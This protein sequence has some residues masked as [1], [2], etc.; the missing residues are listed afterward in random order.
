MNVTKLNKIFSLTAMVLACIGSQTVSAQVNSDLNSW[1]CV[2][3]CGT[4]AADGDITLSP[5]GNAKY[6]YVSTFN[7]TATNVSPLSI[8][9]SGGGGAKFLQTNGSAYTSDAFTLS[10]GQQVEAYFNYVSTDGK[11][12]DDYAWARLVDEGNGQTA[13][14]LFMARSTNSNTGNI[15][16]GDALNKADNNS[17]DF[18]HENTIVNYNNF[19]FNTR[20]TAI[21]DAIDWSQLGDSNGTC[22]RNNAPGCGF[23]GW[24]HSQL[25]PGAG[26]Y[27]LEVGVVNFGDQLYDSGLAFDLVGLTSPVPEPENW[28]LMMAGIC[29]IGFMSYRK[30][31]AI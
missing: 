27:R 9:E 28:S 24:L 1:A 4:S 8:E 17:V 13:A 18:D 26:T 30:R 2:G 14:W 22:W 7:S 10:N 15:V 12:F 3:V 11:G 25:T 29:L 6:G 5:L 19:S 21:Q 16:P 23:T 20:N 31:P